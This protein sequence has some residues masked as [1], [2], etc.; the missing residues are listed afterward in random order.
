MKK[1]EKVKIIKW[2]IKNK[3]GLGKIQNEKDNTDDLKI[4][5][6]LVMNDR[7]YPNYSI[8]CSCWYNDR[9]Y[10]KKCETC[11]AGSNYTFSYEYW[12]KFYERDN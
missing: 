2:Y 5:E 12:K 3:C 10:V 1:E 7:A 9:D 8:C 11:N 6:K 4:L